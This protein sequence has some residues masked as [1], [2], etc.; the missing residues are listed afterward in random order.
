VKE[1]VQQ[2]PVSVQ[3]ELQPA[4][5]SAF[6][7]ITDQSVKATFAHVKKYYKP[8]KL[9]IP[10]TGRILSPDRAVCE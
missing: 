2:N 10:F 1:D 8:C 3:T 4:I 6:S 9:M 5:E 7:R